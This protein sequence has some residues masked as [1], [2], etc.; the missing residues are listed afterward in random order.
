M[1][2]ITH[3]LLVIVISINL[4]IHKYQSGVSLF[5]RYCGV[6]NRTDRHGPCTHGV[7]P[8]FVLVIIKVILRIA[9]SG[10][11]ELL[12]QLNCSFSVLPKI[13]TY[14]LN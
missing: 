14:L 12:F 9:L 3:A 7:I 4:F 5:A 1:L 8:Q 6:G 13:C 11:E 2:P 10:G